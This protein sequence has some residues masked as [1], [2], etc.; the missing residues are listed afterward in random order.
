MRLPGQAAKLMEHHL[1]SALDPADVKKVASTSFGSLID[2]LASRREIRGRRLDGAKSPAEHYRVT[3]PRGDYDLSKLKRRLKQRI[4]W[5]RNG[6][7]G[8]L[9]GAAALVL[10]HLDADTHATVSEPSAAPPTKGKLPAVVYQSQAVAFQQARRSTRLEAYTSSILLLLSQPNYMGVAPALALCRHQLD[11]GLEP[12]LEVVTAL[13]NAASSTPSIDG[14]ELLSLAHSALSS[15]TT[16]SLDLQAFSVVIGLLI[17]HCGAT[18]EQ[19]EELITS[20]MAAEGWKTEV[21]WP[22]D[23]WNL[24]MSVRKQHRDLRGALSVFKRYRDALSS[25]ARQAKPVT[26]PK[27]ITT[28]VLPYMTLL[29]L[30]LDIRKSRVARE[31]PESL[32]ASFSNLPRFVTEDLMTRIATPPVAYLNILFSAQ[33]QMGDVD[34][35]LRLWTLLSRGP[36]EASSFTN[37][38]KLYRTSAYHLVEPSPPTLRDLARQYFTQKDIDPITPQSVRALISAALYPA[39]T[40]SSVDRVDLKLVLLVLEMLR[41]PARKH[42]LE[43]QTIDVIVAAVI[44]LTRRD[45][46]L[47][48]VAFGDAVHIGNRSRWSKQDATGVAAEEWRMASEALFT[49]LAL[50]FSRP[51]ATVSAVFPTA[52]PAIASPVA[53]DKRFATLTHSAVYSERGKASVQRQDAIKPISALIERLV[54]ASARG[55]G[56]PGS[57]PKG[58][59]HAA[60]RDLEKAVLLRPKRLSQRVANSVTPKD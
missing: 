3:N 8:D 30:Y 15:L 47:R 11:E 19:V 2:S 23:M 17:K 46:K 57:A 36:V 24:L 60:M 21:D 25:P 33:R 39:R 6:Q 54:L 29:S 27:S 51:L 49:E 35:A 44:R 5:C 9:F 32:R 10:R 45:P 48:Q 18:P 37:M 55:G 4:S 58:T 43:G 53:M 22:L 38:F 16:E 14:S 42:L 26:D 31:L 13:L 34:A 52:P 41:K 1:A 56:S 7:N 28:L 40:N 59:L 50:P 20:C 12:S